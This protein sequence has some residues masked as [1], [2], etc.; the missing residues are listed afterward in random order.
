[1]LALRRMPC[2]DAVRWEPCLQTKTWAVLWTVGA[3]HDYAWCLWFSRAGAV[4]HWPGTTG[5]VSEGEA[6]HKIYLDLRKA[7]SAVPKELWALS[8][9]QILEKYKLL[10]WIQIISCSQCEERNDFRIDL[11]TRRKHNPSGWEELHR[12]L[13]GKGV[14]EAE[15]TCVVCELW[16]KQGWGPQGPEWE[17]WEPGGCPAVT[18]RWAWNQHLWN[19]MKTATHLQRWWSYFVERA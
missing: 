15:G 7:I 17:A 3:S 6:I 12:V 13:L 14:S 5:C 9:Q 19:Y 11:G 4:E 18:A 10:K 16:G 2:Q 8:S 1:M